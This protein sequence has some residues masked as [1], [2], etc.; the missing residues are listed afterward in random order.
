MLWSG[1]KSATQ[2]P[3][4]DVHTTTAAGGCH[5]RRGQRH[6]QQS[7]DAVLCMM[8]NFNLNHIGAF[9]PVHVAAAFNCSRGDVLV[10]SLPPVR[11]SVHTTTS[12]T[13]SRF[14]L[15]WDGLFEWTTFEADAIRYFTTVVTPPDLAALVANLDGMRTLWEAVTREEVRTE[16]DIKHCIMTYV[17]TIQNQAANGANG[18]PLPSDQ[19]SSFIRIEPG[20]GSYGLIGV[21][22]FAMLNVPDL[23]TTLVGEIKNPWTV[24]PQQIDDVI[25]G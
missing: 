25:D 1:T 6:L 22:D 5:S 11:D 12:T 15:R 4:P 9:L 14:R 3:D 10:T 18:T 7:I 17:Q 8:D 13:K 24:T 20:A 16:A 19:H 23:R 21:S 2:I